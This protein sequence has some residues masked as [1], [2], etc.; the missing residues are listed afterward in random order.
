LKYKKIGHYK[1][2]KKIND[3]AYKVDLLVD[4]DIYLMSN[5]SDLYIFHGENLGDD[6]E[7]EMDWQH[8]IPSNKKE[9]IVHILDKKT[10]PTQQGQY[11]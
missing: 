9:K 2:L 10:L 4:I 8:V 7:A 1:I 5:I 11:N 3:N 6:N